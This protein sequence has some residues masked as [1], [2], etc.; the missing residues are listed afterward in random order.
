MLAHRASWPGRHTPVR[1]LFGRRTCSRPESSGSAGGVPRRALG[2]SAHL[3]K[4][5]QRAATLRPRSARDRNSRRRGAILP[6]RVPCSMPDRSRTSAGPPA[7]GAHRRDR[8]LVLIVTPHEQLTGKCLH[9][10]RAMVGSRLAVMRRS[11]PL[12]ETPAWQKAGRAGSLAEPGSH[13]R[14]VLRPD[15]R[16]PR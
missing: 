15:L 6:G 13:S 3:W 14:C 10:L 1:P 12:L 11:A 8:S 2:A 5:A 16:P 7:P 9:A 4:S